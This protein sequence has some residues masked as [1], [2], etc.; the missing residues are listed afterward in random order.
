MITRLP[1]SILHQH[2]V[3]VFSFH[4][5]CKKSW[6]DQ[7]RQWCIMYCL[8]HP[9]SLLT[10]PLPKDQ[11]KLLMKK[12]IITY[13]ETELRG[14]ASALPSLNFFHP[15]FMSLR[16]PHP[17][18]WTA[19]SSPAKVRKATIQA[20]MLSGRYRTEALT[21]HWTLSNSHGA[22][23]LSPECSNTLGDIT[24]LLQY[25]PALEDTR[26][27]LLA[28]TRFYVM[29]L[30]LPIAEIM[31]VN[32]SPLNKDFFQFLLDCSSLPSVIALVQEYGSTYLTHLYEVSR[33]WVF[34]IHRNRLRRLDR[35]VPDK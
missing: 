26:K 32:C 31:S 29:N 23:L 2:A 24:H 15:E 28:Y 21:R 4:T 7:I 10:D 30:P 34:A 16:R 9:L 20:H 22:C 5:I 13:W 8:P 33:T 3:N 19:G 35:W 27:Y 6:F 11:F 17:I 14:E 25:C 12:K 18:W 1:G